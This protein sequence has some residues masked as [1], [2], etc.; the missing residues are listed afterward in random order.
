MGGRV[1]VDD[2]MARCAL[3]V[4]GAR[5]SRAWVSA[6]RR[7]EFF[8]VEARESETLSPTP[9]RAVGSAPEAEKGALPGSSVRALP[10]KLA[11]SVFMAMSR[12]TKK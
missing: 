10:E 6:S 2:F 1:D 7:N 4:W 12:E 11:A 5:P 9:L 3:T 8:S